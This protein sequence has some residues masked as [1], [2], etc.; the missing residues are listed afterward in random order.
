M[1]RHNAFFVTS[2][3][4]GNYHHCQ[5]TD[6]R[7]NTFNSFRNPLKYEVRKVQPNQRSTCLMLTKIYCDSLSVESSDLLRFRIKA[8]YTGQ[9]GVN[10][11]R[12]AVSVAKNPI[13]RIDDKK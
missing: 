9:E 7:L 5:M 2:L 6:N 8:K 13:Q 4:H 10:E 12:V 3:G 11:K 1:T